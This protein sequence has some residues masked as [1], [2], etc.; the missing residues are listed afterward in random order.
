MTDQPELCYRCLN[1]IEPWQASIR[2]LVGNNIDVRHA[3]EA[4]HL[5]TPK[6]KDT[7][8]QTDGSN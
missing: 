6:P 4:D 7:R 3:S 2:R 1:P 5:P 8:G